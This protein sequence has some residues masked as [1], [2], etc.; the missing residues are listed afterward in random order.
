MA[1]EEGSHLDIPEQSHYRWSKDRG[2]AR[3]G[4]IEFCFCSGVDK[5]SARRITSA[6]KVQSHPTVLR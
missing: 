2:G 4:S 5:R 6:G 3:T 1:F